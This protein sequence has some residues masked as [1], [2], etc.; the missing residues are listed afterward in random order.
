[1][2]Q[3]IADCLAG[4]PSLLPLLH[5]VEESC[6]SGLEAGPLAAAVL[7]DVAA[8]GAPEASQAV[9]R[10]RAATRAR[11]QALA[12]RRRQAVLASMNFHQVCGHGTL[13]SQVHA[14]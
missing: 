3:A 10:L 11:K 13:C 4:V 9:E 6:P 14:C 8:C 5:Q 7:E 1:M 12:A 2:R